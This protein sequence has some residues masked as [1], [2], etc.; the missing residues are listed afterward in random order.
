MKDEIDFTSS[1][2]YY[3]QLMEIIKSQ[4][5]E[6]AWRN[7]EHL[8][9]HSEL[10][11]K[12]GISKTVVR[13][14]LKELEIEGLIIQRRG[15]L[16]TIVDKKISGDILQQLSGTYQNMTRLGYFPTTTVLLNHVIPGSDSVTRKLEIDPESPVIEIE[17]LRYLHDEPFE[18]LRSYIPYDLCPKIIELD[19]TGKSLL[20]EI[21]KEYGY[22]IA[23]S[24]RSIEA[25]SARPIEC[26]LLNVASGAPLLLFNSVS[27]IKSGRAIGT[28]T[29][30]FRGDRARFDVEIMDVKENGSIK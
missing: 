2:P 6:G 1:T 7:E 22:V 3:V 26:K 21:E 4:I 18:F 23:Y 25:V 17:R 19:L 30:L 28:T 27:Y 9:S 16:A 8:P 14:A 10:C 29:S 11:E 13:Q 12:Y 20:E 15:R 5:S 24:K